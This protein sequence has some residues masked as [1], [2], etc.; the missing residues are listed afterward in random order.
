MLELAGFNLSSCVG[1]YMETSEVERTNLPLLDLINE[2]S[3]SVLQKGK[4]PV[5]FACLGLDGMMIFYL[6]LDH[7]LLLAGHTIWVQMS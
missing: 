5:S 6:I 1:T 7:H 3:F 2:R 4:F